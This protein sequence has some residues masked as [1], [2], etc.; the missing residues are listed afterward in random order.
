[1]APAPEPPI[2]TASDVPPPIVIVADV[3]PPP[4]AVPPPKEIVVARV[5]APITLLPTS[6]DD[7]TAVEAWK[8]S[9]VTVTTPVSAIGPG[10]SVIAPVG[11]VKDP[12]DP[13]MSTLPAP[14]TVTD[15]RKVAAPAVVVAPSPRTCAASVN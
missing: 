2:W 12:V 11:D 5:P 6:N 14:V 3:A 9:F 8:K 1:M 10:P 7:V 13:D 4:V 15:D